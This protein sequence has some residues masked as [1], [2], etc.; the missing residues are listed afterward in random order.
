MTDGTPAGTRRAAGHVAGS[1]AGFLGGLAYFGFSHLKRPASELWSA[2]GSAGAARRVTVLRRFAPGSN[3]LFQPFQD[4][5]LLQ[6]FE[7][8][9][10]YRLWKSDGTPEGTA[11]LAGFPPDASRSVAEFLPQVGSLQFFLVYHQSRRPESPLLDRALAHRRQLPRHPE[12]S[13]G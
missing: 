9:E 10:P 8:G 12:G 2:D 11:P 1:D 6:T 3:P 7:T 13:P 5:V 4:G